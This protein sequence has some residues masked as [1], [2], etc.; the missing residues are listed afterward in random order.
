M[1]PEKKKAENYRLYIATFTGLT[2]LT[3]IA[4]GLT[5]IR[6]PSPVMISAIMLIAVF[7]AAFVLFFNMHLK[8][9]DRI[10]LVFVVIVFMLIFLT[11]FITLVD[12]IYR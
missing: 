10:L 7:Q 12:Y 3:L 1:E 5:Q 2:L 8:F 6:L 4:V 11:I 9:H